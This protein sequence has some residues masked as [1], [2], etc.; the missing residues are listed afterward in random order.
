MIELHVEENGLIPHT[1]P[2]T[3]GLSDIRYSS[4]PGYCA[5]RVVLPNGRILK[6]RGEPG[7]MVEV[8]WPGL[9]VTGTPDEYDKKT[10]AQ[11]RG[12]QQG[13]AKKA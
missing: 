2:A 11:L 10:I 12:I 8:T 7:S 3:A 9:V 1:D 5:D 4:V 13:E 6:D